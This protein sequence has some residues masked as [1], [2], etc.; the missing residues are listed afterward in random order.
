MSHPQRNIISRDVGSSRLD[1]NDNSY[2]EV[3]SY[4]LEPKT[5]LLLCSDGL[6]DM[7]T[8]AQMAQVMSS[9]R[10]VQFKVE[11]LIEAALKAGGRDNVTVI[12][13]DI[14][15]DEMPQEDVDVEFDNDFA[16]ESAEKESASSHKFRKL[17]YPW[18]FV[19]IFFVGFAAGVL[20]SPLFFSGNKTV[21][22]KSADTTIVV[23]PADTLDSLGRDSLVLSNE[24]EHVDAQI[25][26]DVDNENQ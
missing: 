22:N 5:Q 20:C 24:A 8:S 2:I 26:Q 18:I 25:H 19:L 3:T 7:I 4:P 12:L 11:M 6:C 9:E 14:E 15:S 17:F 21:E 16:G 1:E 13:V 10:N 23:E